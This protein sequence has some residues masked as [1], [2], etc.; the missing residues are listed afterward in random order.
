[1]LDTLI[2]RFPNCIC[3]TITVGVRATTHVAAD[4]VELAA[5]ETVTVDAAESTDTI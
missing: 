5:V 3:V 2:W 4:D 1:V